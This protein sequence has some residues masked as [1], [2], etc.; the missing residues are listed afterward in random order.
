MKRL[1]RNTHIFGMANIDSTITG[2]KVDIWS[3]H[4]GIMRKV[5]HSNTPRVKVGFHGG[6]SVSVSISSDPKI[7]TTIAKIKKSDMRAI[8]EGIQYV[9][10]HSDIFLKHYM[11]TN[12]S[13]TDLDILTTLKELR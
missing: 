9:A 8:E 2:L 1:I 3:D 13:F 4:S 5:S 6:P 11:D 12:N 10:Q 7:L